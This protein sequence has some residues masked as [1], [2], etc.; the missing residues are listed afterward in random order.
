MDNLSITPELNNRENNYAKKKRI[1]N[2]LLTDINVKQKRHYKKYIKLKKAT[3]NF[4]KGSVFNVVLQ[5]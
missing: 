4:I 5:Y 3:L 1:L 2:T